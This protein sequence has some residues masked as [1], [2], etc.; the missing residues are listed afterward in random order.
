MYILSQARFAPRSCSFHYKAEAAPGIVF[1]LSQMGQQSSQEV[2]KLFTDRIRTQAV[3]K[4]KGEGF[5]SL[6]HS[7]LSPS[8]MAPL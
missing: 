2:R 5:L 7:P 6:L 4:T 8:L 1:S 3:I